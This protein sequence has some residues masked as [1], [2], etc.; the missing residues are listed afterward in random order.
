MSLPLRRSLVPLLLWGCC[1]T[2]GAAPAYEKD[3]QPF[4]KKHCI[5][6]HG[7]KAQGNKLLN[8]PRLAGQEPWYV[9]RQL[10]TW[11]GSWLASAEGAQ[12]RR[13]GSTQRV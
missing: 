4:L 11:Y 3:I 7:D 1:L 13:D 6:C 10:K 9:A 8:D 2:A 5:A 12:R